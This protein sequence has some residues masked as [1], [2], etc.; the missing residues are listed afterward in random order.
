VALAIDFEMSTMIT[1]CDIVCDTSSKKDREIHYEKN[2]I[3]Q[4]S[5]QG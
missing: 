5:D 3:V 2:R 4:E 1:N